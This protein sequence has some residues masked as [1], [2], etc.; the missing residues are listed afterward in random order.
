MVIFAVSAAV[1]ALAA[2]M[3]SAGEFKFPDGVTFTCPDGYHALDASRPDATTT[4]APLRNASDPAIISFGVVLSELTGAAVLPAFKTEEEIRKSLRSGAELV[5]YKRGII[6]GKDALITETLIEKT[7]G[8][9][10]V[11]FL[12]SR[13]TRMVSGSVEM[14]IVTLVM[15]KKRAGEARK[16]AESIENSV[17][18]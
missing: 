9:N 10:D 7:A 18:F 3:A 4:I 1:F 11:S 12:L 13:N 6:A 8:A 14:N 2:G 17:R 5:T 15:D 16:L